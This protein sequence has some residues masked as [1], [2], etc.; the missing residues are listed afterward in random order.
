M[1]HAES[2]MQ[3]LDIQNTSPL[4]LISFLRL[5]PLVDTN[6]NRI[7]A[8]EVLSVLRVG[9]E[10][11]HWFSVLN[12]RDIIK[13]M[14]FQLEQISMLLVK[15]KCFYNLT[16]AALLELNEKDIHFITGFRNVSIEI[17]DT[18]NMK[19]LNID[20]YDDFLRNIDL[21]RRGGINIWLDDVTRDELIYLDFYRNH[22]DGVK[23]DKSELREPW[24]RKEISI[25]QNFLG[26]IDII[27]EG[28]ETESD[29]AVAKETGVKMAQGY[30]WSVDDLY[31]MPKFRP[32]GI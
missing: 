20:D 4:D 7:V 25:I 16:I 26:D 11:E 29:L 27:I 9:V 28:I 23:I 30:L 24:L 15:E 5:E 18:Y 1:P 2:D 31:W 3:K 21:L 14:K 12:T 22:I 8:F 17:S 10:P 32:G 13:V 6:K 19:F